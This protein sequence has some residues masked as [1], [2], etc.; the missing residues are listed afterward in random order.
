[1][2]I[3]STS[4]EIYNLTITNPF[5]LVVAGL[6][7]LILIPMILVAIGFLICVICWGLCLSLPFWGLAYLIQKRINRKASGNTWGIN[8]EKQ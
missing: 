4:V 7:V 6:G 5:A 1:M 2:K 8:N 3:S